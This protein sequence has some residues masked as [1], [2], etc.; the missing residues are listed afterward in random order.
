MCPDSYDR[1]NTIF[2]EKD[3][4]VYI[5]PQDLGKAYNLP[6]TATKYTEISSD[7]HSGFTTSNLG[8]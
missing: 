7:S 5:E 2:R 8:W 6:F 4:G 3:P 1:V